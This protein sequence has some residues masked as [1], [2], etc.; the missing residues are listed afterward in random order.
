MIVPHA[1]YHTPQIMYHI[2]CHTPCAVSYVT[3]YTVRDRSQIRYMFQ[4]TMPRSDDHF[5]MGSLSVAIRV[6]IKVA[7]VLSRVDV[8]TTMDLST[9][10]V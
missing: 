2:M 6:A 10:I 3:Q 9:G 7:L 1:T 5:D 8:W 4:C